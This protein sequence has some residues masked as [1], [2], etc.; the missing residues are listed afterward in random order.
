[1]GVEPCEGR[2]RDAL[3]A[4]EQHLDDA[5]ARR[6]GIA[7]SAAVA[8]ALAIAVQT[9]WSW[10]FDSLVVLRGAGRVFSCVADGTFSGCDGGPGF[11]V[12]KYPLPQYLP[13]LLLNSYGVGGSPALHALALLSCACFAGVIALLWHVPRTMGY[14]LL[15]PVLVLAAVASP[16]VVY[17]TAS[18]GEMLACF[19]IVLFVAAVAER[20]PAL[21]GFSLAAAGTTKEIALPFLLLL[22]AAVILPNLGRIS[23][24]DRRRIAAALVVGS[25][26]AVGLNAGFNVF[27]YSTPLNQGYAAADGPAPL[28]Y[29]PRYFA[30]TIAAPNVGLIFQWP[31]A[32]ALVASIATRW[33]RA[34][35]LLTLIALAAVYSSY[36][37]P[38]G[39]V[40][41]SN[42][43]LI[44]WVPGA[45][46]AAACG[47][48]AATARV[49]ERAMARL[50][51][52]LAVVAVC[53]IAA[54]ANFRAVSVGQNRSF[55]WYFKPDATCPRPIRSI[56]QFSDYAARCRLHSAWGRG[57][58]EAEAALAG[59]ERDG[60]GYT[61]VALLAVGGLVVSAR[62]LG[63]RVPRTRRE[64]A[65][66]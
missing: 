2:R 36:V 28:S 10:T 21:M 5:S 1:M 56:D 27:R 34:I 6:L 58:V 16:L 32:V 43:Y 61:L 39:G 38:W 33:R 25:V 55:D 45:M 63:A 47:S 51:A 20:K 11:E 57:P 35:P 17:A 30:A 49:V 65:A 9:H 14:P 42:R 40:T 53:A 29:R 13:A 12:G 41:W 7:A 23:P 19:L 66:S 62:L 8:A 18:F 46:L 64:Y 24:A 54:V 4:R 59:L 60:L 52:V 44:P 31:L 37:A 50:P 22:A 3:T 26:L 48:P 15:S